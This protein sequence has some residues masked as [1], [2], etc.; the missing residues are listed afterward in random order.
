MLKC[1]NVKVLSQSSIM[2]VSLL[3]IVGTDQINDG[4]NDGG[5]V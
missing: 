3:E 4:T 1:H 5:S 2:T